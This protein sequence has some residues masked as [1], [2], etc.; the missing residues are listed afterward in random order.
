M[1]IR[2]SF[3]VPCR[4]PRSCGSQAPKRLTCGF[5]A[6][7]KVLLP[8]SSLPSSLLL[9]FSFPFFSLP[10]F[11]PFPGFPGFGRAENQVVTGQALRAGPLNKPPPAGAL[12]NR[13]HVTRGRW[14]GS[15]AGQHGIKRTAMKN[16]T[17]EL[18]GLLGLTIL[19]GIP[20]A[21]AHLTGCGK[22][23]RFV[24]DS[25]G[26]I[27]IVIYVLRRVEFMAVLPCA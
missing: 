25:R 18:P 5:R 19:F 14:G 27:C 17:V 24:V 7:K 12:K 16:G 6:V 20:A 13:L 26:R 15:G 4:P 10:L 22:S 1:E 21:I 2:V 11:F 3:P 9:P 23:Q 8:L